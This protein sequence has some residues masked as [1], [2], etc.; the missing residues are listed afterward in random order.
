MPPNKKSRDAFRAAGEREKVYQR[1][2]EEGRDPYNIEPPP[3][4]LKRQCEG[5]G[6]SK[7]SF[8]SHAEFENHQTICGKTH[9]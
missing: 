4:P 5:C 2:V 7:S 3:P 1:I 8:A 9:D 6:L